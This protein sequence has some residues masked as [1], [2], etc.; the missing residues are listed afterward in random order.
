MNPHQ[1]EE[2]TPNH[3]HVPTRLPRTLG[4]RVQ[5]RTAPH[6]RGLA[7]PCG[8]ILGAGARSP[9][10]AGLGGVRRRQRAGVRLRPHRQRRRLHAP[11]RVCRR[12]PGPSPIRR[13]TSRSSRPSSESG[14][15]GQTWASPATAASGAWSG[16]KPNRKPIPR[17]A[18]LPPKSERRR[19]RH[20]AP[21]RKRGDTRRG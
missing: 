17:G 15:C 7:S 13:N 20:Q 1:E 14:L 19:V 4:G 6:L 3:A 9:E 12:P 18:S 16:T 5:R 21:G 11:P 2:D 8:R 10:L